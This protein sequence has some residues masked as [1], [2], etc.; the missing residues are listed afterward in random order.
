MVEGLGFR[1]IRRFGL[2]GSLLGSSELFRTCWD[3]EVG[4]QEDLKHLVVVES[5]APS[6]SCSNVR[7]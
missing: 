7:K 1:L 2:S 3:S 6:R 4:K 5:F